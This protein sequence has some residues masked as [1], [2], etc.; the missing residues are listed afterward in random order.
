MSLILEES[1][2]ENICYY[3]FKN[4]MYSKIQI[5]NMKKE[6]FKYIM[7]IY[8]IKKNNIY[9]I[10]ILIYDLCEL[11]NEINKLASLIKL[12]KMLKCSNIESL[13]NISKYEINGKLIYS[14]FIFLYDYF[15]K[16]NEY[17]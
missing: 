5:K 1:L 9:T 12:E 4:N 6:K 10:F 2:K 3:N 13:E 17:L 8:K 16:L 14:P 7:I 11:D 15:K